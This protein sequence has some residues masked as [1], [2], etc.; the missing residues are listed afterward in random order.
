MERITSRK[1]ARLRHFRRL[2]REREYRRDTGLFLC[3]GEKLLTE[4]LQNGARIREILYRDRA[5]PTVVPEGTAVYTAEDE[6]FDYAS[7]LVNSPGPLFSVEISAPNPV[8]RPERVV[9]LE[10]IQDPGNVGTALRT[11]AALGVHLVIL[12]GDCADPYNPKTVRGAMGALFRQPFAELKLDELAGRLREWDLPFY[13]AALARDS[14]D[15]RGLP[16]ERAAVAVGNEGSGL[17]KEI[18]ALCR[19]KIII[20]MTP[21]SESLNAAVAASVLMWEMVREKL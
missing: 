3:D 9:V 2:G 18:L 21:G 19:K 1:N 17:S 4:A 13:G 14:L 5:V 10:N 6:V 8:E 16:L 7:P 11:A 15:L 12:T 20:P